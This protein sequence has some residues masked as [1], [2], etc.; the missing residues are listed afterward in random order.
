MRRALAGMLVATFLLTSGTAGAA[1]AV[2]APPES[3]LQALYA[4]FRATTVNGSSGTVLVDRIGAHQARVTVA[5]H[6]LSIGH[7]YRL[8][9]SSA[10][11]FEP[12]GSAA[13]IARLH[14]G[15]P[16]NEGAIFETLRVATDGGA[17]RGDWSVRLMEEGG[18]YYS[19][20]TPN[21]LDWPSTTHVDGAFARLIHDSGLSTTIS[22]TGAAPTVSIALDGLTP[23]ARYLLVRSPLT[24]RQFMSGDPDQP[25]VL[26]A[27]RADALGMAFLSRNV[28]V[29]ATQTITVGSLRVERRVDG[30]AWGC[31]NQHPFAL[32]LPPG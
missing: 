2:Q 15:A 12:D 22:P 13:R 11:C 16:D 23:N 9:M 5:L 25:I 28:S 1:A 31:A 27:F 3:F 21:R 19:C 7:G 8:V 30:S 14:L 24:C 6:G 29:G 20:V 26:A 17:W 4:D 18:I 10:R 32:F